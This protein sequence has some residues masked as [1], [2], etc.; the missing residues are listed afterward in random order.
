MFKKKVFN[1]I[2]GIEVVAF[3]AKRLKLMLQIHGRNSKGI[4]LAGGIDGRKY[5]F[6]SQRQCFCKIIQ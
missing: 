1:L 3:F 2:K 4:L 5:D 6:V